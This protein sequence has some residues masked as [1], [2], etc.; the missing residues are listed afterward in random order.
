MAASSASRVEDVEGQRLLLAFGVNFSHQL[1]L[2][3]QESDESD[4]SPAAG[5]QPWKY[6]MCTLGMLVQCCVA[7]VRAWEN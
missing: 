7:T 6:E 4:P 3:A 5:V 2:S 1:G